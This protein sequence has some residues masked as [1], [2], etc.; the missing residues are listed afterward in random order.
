MRDSC[1]L[2]MLMSTNKILLDTATLICVRIVCGCFAL[3]RRSY[4][5]ATETIWPS[6]PKIISSRS[7]KDKVRQSLPTLIFLPHSSLGLLGL[8]PGC[9]LG[10]G[11]PPSVPVWGQ[12]DPEHVL[13]VVGG[14]RI[15]EMM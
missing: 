10:S 15:A 1:I 5:V 12:Q 3:H 9:R 6:Q 11:R 8:F 13:L 2:Q 14:E 7:F 4:G